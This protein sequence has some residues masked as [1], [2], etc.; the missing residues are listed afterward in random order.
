[1]TDENHNSL[2]TLFAERR[3][4]SV[5]ELTRRVKAH[6]E[7]DFTSLLVEGEISNY[8][9]HPSGHWYFSLK[10]AESQIKAVFFRNWNRLVKFVPQN[11]MSVLVRGRLTVYEPQG[12]YQILVE[13]MEPVGVGALQLAFEQQVKRLRA[14]GLFDRER[15]RKLPLLPRRV[16]IVT[17][18]AGAA[19]RDLLQIL[20]RRNRGLDVIIAPVKVQGA[21]AARE[22]AEA[23][24]QLNQIAKQPGR[25]IDVLIVGRGGGSMEDL[26]AFNEEEVARAIHQSEIPVISAVGHETDMTIADL[27]ADVRAATPSAA[28]EIVSAG[29]ADLLMRVDELQTAL[30]RVISYYLLRRKTEW[31]SLI[32]SRG[33]AET[34]NRVVAGKR[35]SHDFVARAAEALKEN[36]RQSRF[37]VHRAQLAIAQTDL[38]SLLANRRSRLTL[39]DQR[40]D[41]AIEHAIER[42]KN[43]LAVMSSQLQMLSPLAVLGRGY[44]IAKDE[45]G[46]LV[47]RAAAVAPG[48]DLTVIFEDGKVE[49]EVKEVIE[50][51]F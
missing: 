29:S 4:L 7:R 47:T 8:K 10:D 49:C 24:R 20:E 43:L 45:A 15:K 1:M 12:N 35:L 19:L 9:S 22:I 16:G 23:I 17:S 5:S 41:R 38:R 3:A 33:F 14:E 28:A 18:P 34:A 25:P 13:T 32:Q 11:G 40:S 30:A 27:V 42:R 39:L 6:L 46:H 37:R 31:R 26:W 44:A 2:D 48:Q 51:T 50:S 21:G 36:L